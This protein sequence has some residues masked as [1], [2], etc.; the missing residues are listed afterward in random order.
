MEERGAQAVALARAFEEADPAGALLR[1]EDRRSATEA[2]RSAGDLNAQAARRA[3][4]L[5]AELGK[6]VRG[7]TLVRACSRIGPGIALLCAVVAFAIGL[8]SDALGPRRQ[9][10]LLSFPLL[11]LFA[12]NI[13]VYLVLAVAAAA[14]FS[15]RLRSGDASEPASD[16][17]SI[18]RRWRELAGSAISWLRERMQ[19]RAANHNP[20]RAGVI[21][22]ALASYWREWAPAFAPL[23]GTRL[24]IALHLGAACLAIGTVAGMYLR[25]LTFAYGVTWESTFLGPEAVA[26]ILRFALAPASL[27]TGQPLPTAA[28]IAALRETGHGHGAALWIHL[29]A[30]TAALV[31]VLP[32]LALAA[33]DLAR[34]SHLA[35]RVPIDPLRGSFRALL[36]P[37]RGAGTEVLVLPYSLR[38]DARAADFLSELLHE[39]FGGQAQVR[40]ADTLGYGDSLDGLR[41]DAVACFV[42]VYPAVQSPEREVHG[43]FLQELAARN[44]EHGVLVIVD[45]SAWAGQRGASADDRR[46][47]E[48]R[49]AWDRV[50]RESGASGLHLDLSAPLPND[51]VERAEAC[52]RAGS[53]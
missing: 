25:G 21:A 44:R 5:L 14:S 20:R 53:P 18:A 52:L 24:R 9:V 31:V 41:D 26:A 6:Q 51:V 33:I 23:A 48:R 43:R 7:I 10:N 2:A 8:A 30:V 3:E 47:A 45:A 19:Q 46:R 37:D 22:H 39:I 27:V 38:L 49:R 15:R 35:R 34:Q 16:H 17:G 12:W 1:P 32:R 36:A 42:V 40:I 29:W 50:I 11:L 13:G 28:D 4:L